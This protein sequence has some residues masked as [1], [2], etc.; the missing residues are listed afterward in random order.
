MIEK[1]EMT[2]WGKGRNNH[3]KTA[4]DE[5]T[6]TQWRHA[7]AVV[8][9]CLERADHRRRLS[10]AGADGVVGDEEAALAVAQRHLALK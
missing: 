10:V 7:A 4:E 1:V 8:C 6:T 3:N 2:D 9:A 5:K